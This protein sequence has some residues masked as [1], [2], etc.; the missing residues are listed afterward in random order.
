[1]TVHA[2]VDESKRNGLVLV[3]AVVAE[4]D[5]AATRAA[6][7]R[8]CL[9][10]QSRVHFT[11]EG[12][13]RRGE[14]ATTICGTS[15]VVDIYDGTALRGEATARSACLEQIVADLDAGGCR[16]LVIE[17]DDAMLAT[18]QAVLYRAVHKLGTRLEYVHQ[19]PSQ[20]PLLWIADAAAWCW[21]RPGERYRI[22]PIVRNVWV[23]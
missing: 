10:G 11:K 17:Q 8:L 1:M 15:V 4:S 19:R 6:M 5:L 3:A 9:R 23:A 14:I 20:D 16:R 13:R 21:T 18:D 22:R 12:R 2:F 7:R